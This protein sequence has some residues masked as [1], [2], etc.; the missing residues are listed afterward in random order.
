MSKLIKTR[1]KYS[2]D[3]KY[4][5][6]VILVVLKKQYGKTIKYIKY[7]RNSK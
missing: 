4:F 5:P 3:N 6:F 2:N 1:L 7:Y